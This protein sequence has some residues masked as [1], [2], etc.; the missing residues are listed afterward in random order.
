MDYIGDGRPR[1]NEEADGPAVTVGI[2]VFNG[3]AYIR[4][5]V[6][7][8]MAQT[9]RDFEILISDN[10][11]TDATPAICA[12]YAAKF[13]GRIRF[14]RHSENRGPFW[15]LK[16]VTDE[17][18]GRLLVWLAH[19]DSLEATYL[20]ECVRRLAANPRS[21]S[22]SSDFRIIDSHGAQ[23]C[24]KT[25]DRIRENITWRRRCPVFF[26]YPIYTD[27]FFCFYGMMR[28]D[29]AKSVMSSC[30]EP[31]YMSQIEL[32][33]LARLA[34][35]GEISSFPGVL[36]NYRRHST[37]L[38]HSEVNSLARKA[39]IVRAAIFLNH[40]RRLIADQMIV[41]IRSPF[42]PTMKFAILFDLGTY[43]CTRALTI[44]H[45]VRRPRPA[46]EPRV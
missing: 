36:R 21:V 29:A 24:I 11:S 12:A 1:M 2:P 6:E 22:V 18:H 30:K 35:K 38:Y 32:P 34:A 14:F 42:A 27:E 25:L 8:V 28:T 5:A 44:L 4:E 26:Q 20:A 39:P 13:A 19:D 31:R 7:S 41:L 15:N 16:F 17:A 46:V 40:A 3:E 23:I 9:Y 45:G 43:Y 10:A 33:V 37:S